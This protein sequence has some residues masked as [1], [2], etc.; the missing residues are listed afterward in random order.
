MKYPL[1]AGITFFKTG[2]LLLLAFV[3]LCPAGGQHLFRGDG[4]PADE[5][6]QRREALSRQLE[7]S[8]LLV[9]KAA[10]SKTRNGDVNYRYRQESNFYYLTGLGIPSAYLLISKDGMAINGKRYTSAI[11]LPEMYLEEMKEILSCEGDTIMSNGNF[12]AFFRSMLG[13]VKILYLS[14]PDLGFVY[15]WLGDKPYF[16]EK[17]AKKTLTADYPDL[18]F[19]SAGEK[20]ARLRVIKSPSETDLIR[21]AI[22][23]TGD[24]LARA[25]SRCHP[26]IWEYELQAEIEYE[27]LR[28]GA[29]SMAFPSI[30]G[31]GPNSLIFHYDENR[32]KAQNGELVVMDVG[33]E[34]CNYAADITRTVPLSGKFSKEQRE[35]YSV[36][37]KAQ[38]EIIGIIRPGIT[39]SDLD[40]KCLEVFMHEGYR[41][42]Y[43]HGVTHQLGLDV[44]DVTAGDTLQAGMIIT[45]EPGI[46]I[47]AS[48]TLLPTEY[49]GIG[50]RIEDDVLVTEK[51]AEI[52]S[53]RIPKS[54][55]DIENLMKK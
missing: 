55:E 44:H 49:H 24:G 22:G 35:V 46:Y 13:E 32:R 39:S 26:G 41:Q 6:C 27:T 43:G 17:N 14:A 50:I 2:M 34:Y 11:F 37:L 30:I 51:G 53:V 9:M 48:D 29:E 4:V 42:Y 33:A 10:E 15:D 20:T 28:Q 25:I 16:I 36:V 21:K 18:K 19:K 7:P 45:V 54:I 38:E 31:S 8:G 23:M 3:W 52:L 47:P 1:P 5:Y 12:Q 40:T